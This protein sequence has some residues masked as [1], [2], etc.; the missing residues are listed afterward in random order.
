DR[1]RDFV[2]AKFD[3][4]LQRPSFSTYFG[5]S[6]DERDA[7]LDVGVYGTMH[8]AG[9]SGGGFVD[10]HG[11]PGNTST[12]DFPMLHAAQ[13]VFAGGRGDFFEPRLLTDAVVFSVVQELTVTALPVNA[14]IGE[15]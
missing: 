7:R 10:S 1:P 8:V 13:P 12:A 9:T 11:Q 5:G 4:D 14:V 15:P 3:S 6:G 2:I